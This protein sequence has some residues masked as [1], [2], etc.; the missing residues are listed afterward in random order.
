[1]GAGPEESAQ[2]CG[3]NRGRNARETL[4][5]SSTKSQLRALSMRSWPRRAR[6]LRCWGIEPAARP[7]K[8][9]TGQMPS[10]ESHLVP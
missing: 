3:S 1:M 8:S 4:I 7:K 9:L 5:V 10:S 6:Q 2:F